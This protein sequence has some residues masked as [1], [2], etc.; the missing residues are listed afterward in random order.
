M[1]DSESKEADMTSSMIAGKL[2]FFYRERKGM[3]IKLPLSTRIAAM[4]R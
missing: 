3:C 1:K 2:T 4:K